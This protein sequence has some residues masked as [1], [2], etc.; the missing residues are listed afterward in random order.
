MF[1]FKHRLVTKSMVLAKLVAGGSSS[2]ERVMEK[3]GENE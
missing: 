1:V 2:I 3:N